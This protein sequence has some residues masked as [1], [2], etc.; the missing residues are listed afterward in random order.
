MM[1][2]NCWE[3][4]CLNEQRSQMSEHAESDQEKMIFLLYVETD[5]MS[6]QHW[7]SFV[8]TSLM[9]QLLQKSQ[10]QFINQC[11]D[12]LQFCCCCLSVS[13]QWQ[14]QLI[15]QERQKFDHHKDIS[16]RQA[17]HQIFSTACLIRLINMCKDL[18]Q[19]NN[20]LCENSEY[21]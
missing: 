1:M 14:C 7:Q 9:H 17:A 12:C 15:Q 5:Y 8:L 6:W 11:Y 3:I 16:V 19:S 2:H 18:H 10:H 21:I 13:H 20:I 4:Q